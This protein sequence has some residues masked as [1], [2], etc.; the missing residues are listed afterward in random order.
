MNDT[1]NAAVAAAA[2]IGMVGIIIYFAIIALMIVSMWKVFAK[3]GQPG[4]ACLIPFYN[5]YVMLQVAGKPGWW[6]IL[7]FIPFVN[8]IMII[9]TLAG[10]ATNFG[11]GVGYVLGLIFL[12]IIFWPMLAFGSAQYVGTATAE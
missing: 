6:L 11:K 8:F 10:I 12:P 7:F 3:G 1:G 2:G 4:W 5:I 9:I